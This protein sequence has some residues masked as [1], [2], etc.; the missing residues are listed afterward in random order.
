MLRAW[1]IDLKGSW[2]DHL[3]LI[4]FSYNNGYHSCIG[5]ELFEALYGRSCRSQIGFFEVGESDILGP[6]IVHEAMKKVKLIR[7]M[8]ATAYRREKSHKNN[9]KRDLEYEVPI[10]ILNRQVKRLRNKDIATVKV[11]WQ[12]H[13]VE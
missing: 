8:L 1:F 5:M 6:K 2:D 3:Q 7:E 4:E 10:E 12:K 9:R 13:L 11:L